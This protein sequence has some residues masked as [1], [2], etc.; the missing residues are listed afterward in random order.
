MLENANTR[1]IY[2][3]SG[4]LYAQVNGAPL[5]EP[6]HLL[7]AALASAAVGLPFAHPICLWTENALGLQS[8]HIIKL[9]VIRE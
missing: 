3:V 2:A 1:K 7:S 5:P 9:R 4:D 6:I 8:S